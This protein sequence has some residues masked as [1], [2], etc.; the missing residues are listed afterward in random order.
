MVV[1][2]AKHRFTVLASQTK[3]V[4]QACSTPPDR[5]QSSTACAP[6]NRFASAAAVASRCFRAS[7]PTVLWP[8]APHPCAPRQPA[9]SRSR[10]ETPMVA[11]KQRPSRAGAQDDVAALSLRVP[12]RQSGA[13]SS[14][15]AALPPMKRAVAAAAAADTGAS[16]CLVPCLAHW[17]QRVK[18]GPHRPL[19]HPVPQRSVQRQTRK[20][21]STTQ[22]RDTLQRHKRRT[23]RSFGKGLKQR[24]RRRRRLCLCR[25]LL[26]LT[27]VACVTCAAVQGR[28]WAAAVGVCSR[29]FAVSAA[30][31][32]GSPTCLARWTPGRCLHL[33]HAGE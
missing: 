27:P 19:P 23:G 21:A 9:S 26:V 4:A 18:S 8:T 2:R 17:R 14:D 29:L 20:L 7:A 5:R 33:L 28:G 13:M 10:R 30:P 16:S 25:R 15:H 32:E 24:P 3:L 22:P 31:G 1:R 11:P 12:L 6:S